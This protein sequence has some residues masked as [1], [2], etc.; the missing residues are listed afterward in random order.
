MA[1]KSAWCIGAPHSHMQWTTALPES[2]SCNAALL[3]HFRQACLP[4]LLKRVLMLP[5]PICVNCM[6]VQNVQEIYED[7]GTLNALATLWRLPLLYLAVLGVRGLCIVVLNP[8]F[9]LAGT[10]ASCAC[11]PFTTA[12]HS[13]AQYL[14]H[15]QCGHRCCTWRRLGFAP[16]PA[17]H[18]GQHQSATE[19][20]QPATAALPT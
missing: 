5:E 15:G 16:H 8:L 13:F 17:L 12:H 9:K 2:M 19:T 4:M 18:T 1:L 20:A 3:P 10:G 14:E 11:A 6:R 7:E